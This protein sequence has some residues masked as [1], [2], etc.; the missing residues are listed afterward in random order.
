MLFSP[1]FYCYYEVLLELCR[2]TASSVSKLFALFISYVKFAI[3]CYHKNSNDCES[4]FFTTISFPACIRITFS[5]CPSDFPPTQQFPEFFSENTI[6]G[7]VIINGFI[8]LLRYK[9]NW[10]VNC[11]ILGAVSGEKRFQSANAHAGIQQS[12]NPPAT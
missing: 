8:V 6:S 9:R 10:I 11:T 5:C 4:Y 3:G 12:R 1:L 2:S 7:G